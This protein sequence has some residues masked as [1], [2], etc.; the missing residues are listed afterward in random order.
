M[1]AQPSSSRRR[2]ASAGQDKGSDPSSADNIKVVL[3]GD[4]AVG[5]TALFRRWVGTALD[6]EYAPSTT[7]SVGAKLLRLEGHE[8]V[9]VE[10]WDVPHQSFA[11]PS[12]FARYFRS[13]QAIV[14][15]FSLQAPVSWRALPKF[16]DVARQEIAAS[17]S[18]ET[19]S[20]K[21]LSVVMV[22]N[23]SDCIDAAGLEEQQAARA[24]CDQHGVIYAEVSALAGDAAALLGVLKTVVAPRPSILS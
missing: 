1:G 7:A 9:V 11:G 4:A 2:H 22:G 19:R 16:L 6:A 17:E 20:P 5:K 13:T 3:L 10:L 18:I 21:D 23:K 12:I 8:P 14:L 15:V 24:W